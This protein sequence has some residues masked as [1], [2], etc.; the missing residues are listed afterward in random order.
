MTRWLGFPWIEL[1][2][3]LQISAHLLFSGIQTSI[4]GDQTYSNPPLTVSVLCQGAKPNQ[5]SDQ[6]QAMKLKI[7]TRLYIIVTD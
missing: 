1:M 7:L 3:Y 5:R 6:I 2:N 4:T